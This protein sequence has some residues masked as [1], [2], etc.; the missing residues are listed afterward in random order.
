MATEPAQLSEK[1]L[2]W[3]HEPEISA[4]GWARRCS[5]VFNQTGSLPRPKVD[6]CELEVFFAAILGQPSECVTDCMRPL[7]PAT[8][9]RIQKRRVLNSIQVR[10]FSSCPETD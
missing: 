5:G 7:E 6:P 10:R 9:D 2:R 1:L 3:F 8:R 4:K